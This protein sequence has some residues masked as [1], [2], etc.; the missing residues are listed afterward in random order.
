VA[1]VFRGN[2]DRIIQGLMKALE[3]YERDH[4]HADITLYRQNPVA[5]RIRIIDPDLA[6]LD[7]VQRH[8]RVWSYFDPLPE[9]TV[10]DITVLLLL[11][12]DEVKKSFANVDFEDPVPSGL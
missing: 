5:V 8:D 3:A 12:P 11:T 1:K 7:K 10:S 9:R 2:S 4:P 6:G